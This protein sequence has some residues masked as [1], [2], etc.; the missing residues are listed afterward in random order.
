MCTEYD[1]QL[2]RYNKNLE[3]DL[4]E[5]ISMNNK[6]WDALM[7]VAKYNKSVVDSQKMFSTEMGVTINGTVSILKKNAVS[8]KC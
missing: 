6:N 4:R 3:R 5:V 1:Y 2:F 8:S 7:S